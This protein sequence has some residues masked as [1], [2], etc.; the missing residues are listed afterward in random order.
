M[1]EIINFNHVEGVDWKKE[2]DKRMVEDKRK[3]EKA[4]KKSK[5]EGY[6]MFVTPLGGPSF[7][8]KR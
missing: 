1:A 6:E 4:T 7:S 8:N 2:H 5:E 3:I